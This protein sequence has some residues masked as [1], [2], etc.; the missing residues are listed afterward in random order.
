[1]KIVLLKVLEIFSKI[2]HEVIFLMKFLPTQPEAKKMNFIYYDLYYT[3]IRNKDEKEIVNEKYEDNGN[4]Y[5]NFDNFIT[6]NH[7][8]GR[9]IKIKFSGRGI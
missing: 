4:D 8:M 6:P 5:I 3:V 9:K 1:M 7:Y 2:Y